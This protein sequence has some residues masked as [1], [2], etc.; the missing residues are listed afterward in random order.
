MTNSS[1]SG[2]QT[3][4]ARE[5]LASFTSLVAQ[6]HP[7]AV[8]SGDVVRRATPAIL[9]L[10][11]HDRSYIGQLAP[12]NAQALKESRMNRARFDSD[13]DGVKKEEE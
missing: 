11:A 4:T 2:L 13:G 10:H 5:L 8:I 7:A 9:A 12:A 3:L 6:T 1:L